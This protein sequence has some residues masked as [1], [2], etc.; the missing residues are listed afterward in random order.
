[1]RTVEGSEEFASE[2]VLNPKVG[3][4][5]GHNDAVCSDNDGVAVTWRQHTCKQKKRGINMEDRYK[6]GGG[7]EEEREG[8]E[9]KKKS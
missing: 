5:G 3:V 1:M 9:E 6:T 2:M 4:A 8:G 7:G